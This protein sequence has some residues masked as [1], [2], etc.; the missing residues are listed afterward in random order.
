MNRFVCCRCGFTFPGNT[1][2]TYS[3]IYGATSEMVLCP[4]CAEAE[5]KQI[6]GTNIQPEQLVKYRSILRLFKRRTK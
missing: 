1:L 4:D 6:I 3:S 2:Q 5:E